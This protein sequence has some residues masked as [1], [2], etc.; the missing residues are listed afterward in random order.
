MILRILCWERKSWQDAPPHTPARTHSVG[1]LVLGPVSIRKNW[2]LIKTAT[3][4]LIKLNWEELWNWKWGT[5]TKQGKTA[6]LGQRENT[7]LLETTEIE[8]FEDEH[9]PLW[10]SSLTIS[11]VK[12]LRHIVS[13]S[14]QLPHLS[15]RECYFYSYSFGKTP[16]Y[17][18]CRCHLNYNFI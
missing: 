7:W 18:N 9:N 10:R 6:A 14:P 13:M 1:C 16:N 2:Q 3:R 15:A 8:T 5:V 12:L 4:H 11:H 17:R